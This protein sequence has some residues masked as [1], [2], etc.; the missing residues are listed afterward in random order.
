MQVV[1]LIKLHDFEH[2]IKGIDV[3][4]SYATKWDA[5]ECQDDIQYGSIE[6]I[7]MGEVISD[8]LPNETI[9][10]LRHTVEADWERICME[11][12]EDYK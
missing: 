3:I 10:G 8:L 6:V 12:Q 1:E 2:Q 11:E 7:H 4:V 9:N 5:V